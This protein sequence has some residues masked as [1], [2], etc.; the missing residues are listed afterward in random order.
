M[1]PK[2]KLKEL[3]DKHEKEIDTLRS[4]C[5]HEPKYI[6]ITESNACVGAGSIYPSVSVICRNCGTKK[7]IFG[8]DNKK[9][10][11][12]KKTMKRQ[13]FKDERRN[14]PARFEYE[15]E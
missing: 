11:T 5:K 6:K 7:I 13:G 2:S 1:K 10:K 9:R 4:N 15:I 12:V 14:G 3:W 8:L